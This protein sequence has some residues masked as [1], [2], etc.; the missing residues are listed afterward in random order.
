ML[1]ERLKEFV[2]VFFF[3]IAIFMVALLIAR[4][5]WVRLE[6]GN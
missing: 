3:K 5:N 1:L 6:L 2:L 4:H